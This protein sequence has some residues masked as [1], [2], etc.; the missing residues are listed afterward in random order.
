MVAKK[1]VQYDKA[2]VRKDA[3]DWF[4]RLLTEYKELEDKRTKLS[5]FLLTKPFPKEVSD[6]QRTLL[7]KQL[8]AMEEYAT[9]LS[10]RINLAVGEYSKN[11]DITPLM[12]IEQ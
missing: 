7:E 10:A 3:P 6:I 1:I 4:K 11:K 9:I 5:K 2:G 12:R 8:V